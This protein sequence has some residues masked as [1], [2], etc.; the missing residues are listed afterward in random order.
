MAL[1]PNRGNLYLCYRLNGLRADKFTTILSGF[2]DL[3]YGAAQQAVLGFDPTP[4][5]EYE[6]R[7]GNHAQIPISTGGEKGT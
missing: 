6:P 2:S 1:W 5:T 4:F 3:F 7:Y